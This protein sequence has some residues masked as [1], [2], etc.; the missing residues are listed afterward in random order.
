M[1]LQGFVVRFPD[2]KLPISNAVGELAEISIGPTQLAMQISYAD[3][4]KVLKIKLEEVV[5][6]INK[7]TWKG[8]G[9]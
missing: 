6:A 2:T 1:K 9:C 7:K 5:T 4:S 3:L 8:Q